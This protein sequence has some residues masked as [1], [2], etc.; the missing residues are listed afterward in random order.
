[1]SA[2]TGNVLSYSKG[3][4]MY[5]TIA[6]ILLQRGKKQRRT[7]DQHDKVKMILRYSYKLHR[8]DI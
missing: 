7:L 6:S 2:E 4:K 1:M 8:V 3:A 5:N